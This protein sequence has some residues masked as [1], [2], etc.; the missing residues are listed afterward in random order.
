[1]LISSIL[2]FC[3]VSIWALA[4]RGTLTLACQL[5]VRILTICVASRWLHTCNS[6]TA[7]NCESY[8]EA[9]IAAVV[10]LITMTY[11]NKRLFHH[12]A[13]TYVWKWSS[14]ML[15]MLYLIPVTYC[16]QIVLAWW[17]WKPREGVKGK[18][19][20]LWVNREW[21]LRLMQDFHLPLGNMYR[22]H[23]YPQ[24]L[25]SSQ[26]SSL[27]KMQEYLDLS[28]LQVPWNHEL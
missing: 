13:E 17:Q 5:E 3:N 27:F 16:H 14:L 21:T 11:L 18:G 2:T 22:R 10:F 8:V 26:L 23:L 20:E 1:M 9:T 19:R 28:I 12:Q 15:E 25:C 24:Q 6:S 7:Y 4:R